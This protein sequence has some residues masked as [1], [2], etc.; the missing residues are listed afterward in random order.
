MVLILLK[1]GIAPGNICFVAELF[2]RYLTVSFETAKREYGSFERYI[3]EG[4]GFG[5]E[6]QQLLK[7]LYLEN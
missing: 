7:K 4:I 5:K 3:E 2:S 6:E 1:N